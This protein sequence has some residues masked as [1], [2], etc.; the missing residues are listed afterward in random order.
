MTMT[1][2]SQSLEK[3]MHKKQSIDPVVEESM[4]K[5]LGVKIKEVNE[6]I[7]EK[8]VNPVLQVDFDVNQ[9][10]K[11]AKKD[12]KRVFILTLLQSCYG[13]VSKVASIAGL[14]RRSIHRL[15]KKF[16]IN[17]ENLRKGPY[18]FTKDQKEN[19]VY[20]VVED[21]LSKYDI[22]KNKS[23]DLKKDHIK[24]ISLNLPDINLSYD[25]AMKE[26]EIQFLTRAL[27][28]NDFNTM[29]TAKKIGIAKETLSRKVNN[30]GIMSS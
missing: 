1:K 21:T 26:F 18:Y 19:Y 17:I 25:D 28:E 16:K 11:D 24:D 13:N 10:F 15:I 12:F 29:L 4:K 9:K 3:I 7:S 27:E 6:D 8:L 22:T 5:F 30:L 20:S 2:K 23:Y 14:D